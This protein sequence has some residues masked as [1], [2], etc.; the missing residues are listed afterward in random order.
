VTI[1][2]LLDHTATIWRRTTTTGEL[3][4]EVRTWSQVGSPVP[5]G[6][7]RPTARIGLAGGGLAAIGERIIYLDAGVDVAER[8]VI[9]LDSGPDTGTFEVDG[10]VTSPRGHHIELRTRHWVGDLDA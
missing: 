10:P 6:V 5:C 1:R 3:R 2:H 7:R 4:E 9:Q 8:D